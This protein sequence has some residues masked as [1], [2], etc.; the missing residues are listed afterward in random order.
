MI[1]FTEEFDF[2]NKNVFNPFFI[3]FRK[4]KVRV[5]FRRDFTANFFETIHTMHSSQEE[6]NRN[7]AEVLLVKKIFIDSF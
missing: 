2:E 6:Q 4:E 7:K 3:F 5:L 1:L